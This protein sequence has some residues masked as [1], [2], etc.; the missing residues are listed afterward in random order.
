MEAIF[1]KICLAA[2]LGVVWCFFTCL[3]CDAQKDKNAVIRF[4]GYSTII[5]N[6]IIRL[7]TVRYQVFFYAHWGRKKMCINWY[8]CRYFYL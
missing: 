7:D 5:W 3:A 8:L 1:I 6:K 2:V 4:L